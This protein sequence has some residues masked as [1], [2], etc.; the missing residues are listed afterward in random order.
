M[1]FPY[2]LPV[3]WF[4]EFSWVTVISKSSWELTDESLAG[5]ILHALKNMLA[6]AIRN[7]VS[8]ALSSFSTILVVFVVIKQSHL[9]QAGLELKIKLGMPLTFWSCCLHF[10]SAVTTDTHLHTQLHFRSL[11][12]CFLD[13]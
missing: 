9:A 7:L 2:Y 8:R 1:F 4:I 13:L 11:T 10:P 12:F 3:L 5:S 6:L